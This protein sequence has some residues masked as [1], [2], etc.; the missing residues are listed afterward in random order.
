MV[1]PGLPVKGRVPD[2]AP[3]TARISLILAPVLALRRHG[4]VETPRSRRSGHPRRAS[5]HRKLRLQG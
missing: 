1:K 3:Q 5:T 2:A 4:I